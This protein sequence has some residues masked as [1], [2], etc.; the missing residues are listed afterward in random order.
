MRLSANVKQFLIVGIGLYLVVAIG[1]HIVVDDVHFV[2]T[3]I[4]FATLLI[5]VA[6]MI[7]AII[8]VREYMDRQ[9]ILEVKTDV[10]EHKLNG[11]LQDAADQAVKENAIIDAMLHQQRK[12]QATMREFERSRDGCLE[13]YDELAQKHESLHEWIIRR[14]D[15]SGMGRSGPRE[16]GERDESDQ[17]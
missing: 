3:G 17:I 13:K 8:K 1:V 6:G 4:G 5:G 7:T 10:L 9:K 15:E 14:L 2:I 11:G 16:E 12:D